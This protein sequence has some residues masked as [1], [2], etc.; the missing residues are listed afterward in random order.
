[1]EASKRKKGKGKMICKTYSY[2]LRGIDAVLVQVEI[3][4]SGGLPGIEMVGSL[5]GEVREAKERV[6]VAV[7]NSGFVLPARKMT[8]NLSPADIRKAGTGYDLAIALGILCGLSYLPA[9]PLAGSCMVGELGLDG[10]VRPVPGV[11]SCAYAAREQGFR[12]IL[13]PE[14][15]V[16][17]AAVMEGIEVCGVRDLTEAARFFG[18]RPANGAGSETTAGAL[19]CQPQAERENCAVRQAEDF[20]ELQGQH[21]ARRAAEIAAAGRHNLLLL[22]PPGAGKTML[23]R[24]IPGIL[25]EMTREEA[26]EVSRIYSVA[27]LLP[28]GGSLLRE[29]PFRA[30]HHSCT[31]QALTGGG[32]EARP[33]EISLATHGVL[34]LDEFPEFHRASVEALRQPLEERRI[35]VSRLY[36]KV[37][38]PAGFLLVAAMNPCPCGYYPDRNRCRCTSE[39]IR[40]YL[41]K[42][43][44][45]VLERMDLCVEMPE[46]S[47]GEM[48]A[49]KPAES[50]E[51][52]RIRVRRAAERQR[53]RYA[54]TK[55]RYN[56]EAGQR[57]LALFFRLSDACQRRL[58]QS[59]EKRRFSV[60]SYYRMIRVARTIADLD[61]S[62]EI[63]ERHMTEA[64]CYHGMDAVYREE[65]G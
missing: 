7:K 62:E 8:V 37:V 28:E 16:R 12:R 65:P 52:I 57:E 38:Y 40:R 3:D 54:G 44:Q 30:P 18:A 53:E 36:G 9:E 4:V 58:Q 27:G 10:R 1:M 50:S 61:G 60:R 59:Y 26:L 55:L 15:N 41:G 32:R 64:I 19:L 49:R 51:S 35:L 43:S 17:E 34:F 31:V 63:E 22:G 11:L 13:V 21:L 56:S 39:Q 5:S 23:A 29:R 47:F 2:A 14:A 25:P 24:R 20:S 48:R 33:G 42:I 46:V 45:P 6:R